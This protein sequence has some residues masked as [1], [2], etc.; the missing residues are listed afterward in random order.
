MSARSDI[1]RICAIDDGAFGVIHREQSEIANFSALGARTVAGLDDHLHQI[2]IFTRYAAWNEKGRL[3]VALVENFEN[4]TGQ[5]R[6][7]APSKT[8]ANS[9]LLS[10]PS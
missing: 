4:F 5:D 2:R 8:S 6:I 9:P 1:H 10:I 7:Q 3:G